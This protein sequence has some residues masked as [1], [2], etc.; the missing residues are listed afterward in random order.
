MHFR[1]LTEC[2]GGKPRSCAPSRSAG[3]L[4]PEPSIVPN[5]ESLRADTEALVAVLY[6][7]FHEVP[8]EQRDDAVREFAERLAEIHHGHGQGVPEWLD[9]LRARLPS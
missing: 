7:A 9:R 6:S 4:Q 1:T 8:S 3:V 5:R 2:D